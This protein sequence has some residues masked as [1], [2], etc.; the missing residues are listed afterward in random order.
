MEREDGNGGKAVLS[1]RIGRELGSDPHAIEKGVETNQKKKNRLTLRGDLSK[2]GD[3]A[4][5]GTAYKGKSGHG[6]EGE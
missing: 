4:S 5:N 3:G 2:L 1:S 6:G